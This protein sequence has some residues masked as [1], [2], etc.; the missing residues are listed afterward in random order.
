[1]DASMEDLAQAV[2][3]GQRPKPLPAF[4]ALIGWNVPTPDEAGAALGSEAPL[5][6]SQLERLARQ[7]NVLH[8]AATRRIHD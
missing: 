2:R 5:L 4:N 1:M 6:Q 3:H 8:A 7:I